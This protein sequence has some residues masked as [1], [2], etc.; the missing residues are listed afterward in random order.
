MR[1]LPRSRHDMI[2]RLQNAMAQAGSD[3]PE[4][5]CEH[6]ALMAAGRLDELDPDDRSRLLARI[7]ADPDAGRL[8]ADLRQLGLDES[9]DAAAGPDHA[10]PLRLLKMTAVGWAV[11]ACMV[12]GLGLWRTAQPPIPMHSGG[13]GGTFQVYSADDAAPDYWSQ[14]NHQRLQH[15]VRRDRYRD[16][17][18]VFSGAASVVLSIGMIICLARCRRRR[19]A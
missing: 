7:A 18:L 19:P 4:L 10:R 12:I 6:L 17:A 9:D 3:A 8:L 15:R 5:D 13:P 16:Y 11:A 2:D 14:V 1:E